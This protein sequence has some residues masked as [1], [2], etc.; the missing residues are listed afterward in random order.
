MTR[1]LFRAALAAAIAFPFGAAAQESGESPRT[2]LVFG[3]SIT[4]GWVPTSPIVPT[5]RHAKADRWPQIMAEALGEGYEVVTE[6]LSGRTTNVE[7]ETAPGLMNGADYLDS[8]LVSHAPID[9]VVIMLGTNDTKTYLDRS[10]LEIGLGMGALVNIVQEGSGLGWYTYED[11]VPEILVVSPPPLGDEI[12]PGA[13]A[14]FAEGQEKI[15]QL[16]AIYEA[17]AGAAGAR[18][19][20]A[21]SVV[22]KEDVGPDGIHLLVEGNRKLGEAVAERVREVME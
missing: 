17:I 10:P 9:M 11:D 14:D 15:A 18:F 5:T 8:A 2:V 13:A 22:A 6:G 16:P 12:D 3:D 20:D 1:G 19:F 7:D 4:W 21:A